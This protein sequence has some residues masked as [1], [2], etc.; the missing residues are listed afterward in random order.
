MP[1][2]DPADA[3]SATT[4]I[5]PAPLPA[6]TTPAAPA[7]GSTSTPASSGFGGTSSGFGA[8]AA[9][10]FGGA[11]SGGFG[12]STG[13]FGGSSS[14]FGGSTGGFGGSTGGFGGSTGG[15]GSPMGGG[16]GQPGMGGMPMGQA[17]MLQSTGGAMQEG[18][19]TTIETSKGFG[20]FIN[21][22]WRPMMAV[23][24]M[25]TCMTDF[26]IFPVLWSVL[27]ALFHGTVT[28]QWAPLTLQGAGLYH[29]AMGAV[30]GL[31]AYGRSQE[32]IAGK[33]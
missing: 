32:K 19:T 25:V 16:M 21:S 18:G 30:L 24:Y 8:P 22:K 12:G 13:G 2:L 9:G 5:A 23:I 29:I 26:V 15:F 6:S 7:F 31:A 3:S 10:G 14:G 28:S 20:D 4:T 11:S 33:A 27:Q 17:Q 1:K